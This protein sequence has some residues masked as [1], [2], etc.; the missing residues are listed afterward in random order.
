MPEV[1]QVQGGA[2]QHEGEG[3]PSAPCSSDRRVR[4]N[5]VGE[6]GNDG[7]FFR[8]RRAGSVRPARW[9]DYRG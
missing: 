2:E 3:Q 4:G 9:G 7:T 6:I 5:D 8:K 1:A